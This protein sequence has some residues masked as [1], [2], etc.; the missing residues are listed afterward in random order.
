MGANDMA[1]VLEEMLGDFPE[2][3]RRQLRRGQMMVTVAE[4]MA[5]SL[6]FYFHLPQDVQ[7]AVR[8]A[9]EVIYPPEPNGTV[10][11]CD[12]L[13]DIDRVDRCYYCDALLGH[14]H[15]KGCLCRKR[16]NVTVEERKAAFR[17]LRATLMPNRG[18]DDPQQESYV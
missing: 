14:P 8:K 15:K 7:E 1:T 12:A 13:L 17:V 5:S 11:E 4:V 9:I 16:T 2:E 10:A 18:E 3:K 6:H